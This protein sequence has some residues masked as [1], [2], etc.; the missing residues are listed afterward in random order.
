MSQHEVTQ[1]ARVAKHGRRHVSD[2]DRNARPQTRAQ[3]AADRI[4]VAH[5][6]LGGQRDHNRI[7]LDAD[8]ALLIVHIWAP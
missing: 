5:I 7:R 1:S 3:I 6:D 4:R 8:Q 2:H